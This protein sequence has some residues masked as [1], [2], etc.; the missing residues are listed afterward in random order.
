M[1]ADSSIPLSGP[2]SFAGSGSLGDYLIALIAYMRSDA[3]VT[4]GLITTLALSVLTGLMVRMILCRILWH[5]IS[6]PETRHRLKH[7]RLGLVLG[8]WA[9]VAMFHFGFDFF[10]I[11]ASLNVQGKLDIADVTRVAIQA[12]AFVL[13]FLMIDRLLAM[14]ATMVGL[15]ARKR[16]RLV[17]SYF[18]FARAFSAA[19]GL[20]L[21]GSLLMGHSPALV[22]TGIGSFSAL[23]LLVFRDTIL[24]LIAGL[25]IATSDM[26]RVGDWIT[27]PKLG[28]DGTVVDIHL[29]QVKIQNFDMTIETVPT[30]DM[31]S[32]AVKNWRGMSEFGGR[33]VKRA[34]Y[35]DPASIHFC[36][37]AMLEDL[38]N[39]DLLRAELDR[40]LAAMDRFEAAHRALAGPDRPRTRWILNAQNGVPT[41]LDLYMRYIERFI[42]HDDRIHGDGTRMVRQLAPT[43]FGALPLEIYAFLNDTEW[44]HY[45]KMTAE[46]YTHFVAM[47]Q[48]FD[49]R[50]FTAGELDPGVA[51]ADSPA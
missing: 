27:I 36:D 48:V 19:V 1:N 3:D 39:I 50:L 46:I 24:S 51:S 17:R 13:T 8:L 21:G 44:V 4:Y 12:A 29:Y 35:I 16:L 42:V 38:A 49:L 40:E 6:H 47:A 34:I 18:Q 45:E 2:P 25:E 15:S 10:R 7:K 23:I 32:N 33:R 41:N 14:G 37:R 30:Y 11:Y 26:I 28:V 31:V 43:G 9:A 5:H 20:F 22:L